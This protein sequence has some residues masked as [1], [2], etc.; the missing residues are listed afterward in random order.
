M[1]LFVNKPSPYARKVLVLLHEKGALGRVQV[2]NADPWADPADLLA[3]TPLAKVPTLVTDEGW[4]LPESWAIADYLDTVLPGPRLLPPEPGPRG[5]ELRLAALGQG[6]TDAA[7]S[8]VIEGRRLEGERSPGWVERQKA[9]ILRAMPVLEAEART[10][11]QGFGMGALSVAVALDYLDFRHA[12]LAWR[13]HVP[14]L[15]EW[16]EEVRERP[17]L[18]ATDPRG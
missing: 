18:R 9:A 14:R 2:V 7:F 12:G 17:S 13:Q 15:R 4:T 3:A 1:K 5:R 11:A 8:A 16:F 6:V 10:L